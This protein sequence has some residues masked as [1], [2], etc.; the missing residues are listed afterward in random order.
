MIKIMRTTKDRRLVDLD[1]IKSGAW[2]HLLDP[3]DEELAYVKKHLHIEDEFLRAALDEEETVRIENE[4]GQTLVVVDIPV[5]SPERGS[6]LYT[7]L[8]LGIILAGDNIVTVCLEET[9]II[10]DFWNG[11]VKNFD[12]CKRSR[13]LLQILYRNAGNICSIC[14]R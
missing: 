2:I 3:N 12:T 10:E 11:R 6:F 14:V 9:S 5:V 8:P 4:D 1:E 13:F 7:T